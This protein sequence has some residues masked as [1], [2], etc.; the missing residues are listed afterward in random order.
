MSQFDGLADKASQL[1]Q[2]HGDKIEGASDQ[3]IQKGGD[4]ADEKTGGQ[5]S[6]KVDQAT[7]AADERIGDN[8]Q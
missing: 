5:H 2:E 3:A 4:F 7:Q 8:S 1:N 6:D